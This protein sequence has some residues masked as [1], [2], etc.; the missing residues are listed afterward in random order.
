MRTRKVL[1]LEATRIEQGH[2]QRIAQGQLRGGAGG[3]RQVQ[4]A[5][6]LLDAAVQKHVGIARQRGLGIARHGDQGRPHALEHGQNGSQFSG[7]PAVGDG[8]HQI[9]R[10]DHAQVTMAGLGGV[11]K[12]G[13]RAGGGQGCRNL[14][15]NVAT[16]AH[17]HHHHAAVD[18]QHHLHHAGKRTLECR[19]QALN[20]GSFNVQGF[21]GQAD[22]ALGLKRRCREVK[23][24]HRFILSGS[25][26]L[27]SIEA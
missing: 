13:G 10:T 17:A 16:F 4:G 23:W 19:F 6:L 20:G 22:G 25:H 27:V 24:S 21:A 7:L 14:A 12:H 26:W 18:P 9:G 5:G 2:G 1:G 11:H 8:Q 15:S 3:R